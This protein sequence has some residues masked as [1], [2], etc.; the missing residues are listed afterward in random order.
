MLVFTSSNL[1]S[2]FKW[3]VALELNFGITCGVIPLFLPLSSPPFF[4][5]L[6][7]LMS[8]QQIAFPSTVIKWCGTFNFVDISPTKKLS[9]LP[10]FNP[11]ARF[12]F[13]IIWLMIGFGG[14]THPESSQSSPLCGATS[15]TLPW[16]LIPPFGLGKP[17]LMLSVFF[18]TAKLNKILN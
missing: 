5:W 15:V 7:L 9:L 12:G 18:W 3:V 17:L 2:N 14:R 16:L 10:C 6:L 11:L 4:S 1:A 13:P 8:S